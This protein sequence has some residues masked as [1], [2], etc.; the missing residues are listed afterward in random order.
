VTVSFTTSRQTADVSDFVVSNATDLRYDGTEKA[1]T[2][3]GT[4]G[5]EAMGEITISYANINDAAGNSIT[6]TQID[7]IP[8][9][10]GTYNI[11]LQTTGGNQFSPV[12]EPLCIDEYTIQRASVNEAIDSITSYVGTY[13]TQSHNAINVQL[14]SNY[15]D[16]EISYRTDN[17]SEYQTTVPTVRAAGD[18]DIYVKISGDDNY[19]D[20]YEMLYTSVITP[21]SLNSVGDNLFAINDSYYYTG[22]N[23]NI[24]PEVRALGQL[25][26][27][28]IDYT[29][30]FENN[31]DPHDGSSIGAPAITV[32]GQG[33]YSGGLKKTFAIE[34]FDGSVS[35]L[36]KGSTEEA[37]WYA[38]DVAIS[39][40]GYTISD[41]LSGTFADVYMITGSGSN[42][43][44]MLYFKQD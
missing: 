14:K 11:Y 2:V 27:R 30:M 21:Y 23:V 17:Q 43:E 37:V 29:V 18:T 13:D 42:V 20:D 15:V 7:G 38:D 6:E 3:S 16:L 9:D 12:S 25:L 34:F 36:Y 22:Q 40:P 8:I 5:V 28:G 1:V 26:Q 39:A 44:K 24:E 35:L 4:G 33:N 32:I 41:R 19:Y 31:I 10:A